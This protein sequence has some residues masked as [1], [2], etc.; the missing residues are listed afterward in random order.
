MVSYLECQSRILAK[1]LSH[2]PETKNK[3]KLGSMT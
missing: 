1:S 3:H 2:T